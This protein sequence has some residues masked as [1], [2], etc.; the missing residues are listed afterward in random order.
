MRDD[1][2]KVLVERPRVRG[3]FVP[4]RTGRRYVKA[5]RSGIESGDGS[6]VQEGIMR[7]YRGG[8]GRVKH[9]NEHLGP[10]RRF[11]ESNVGRPWDKV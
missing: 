7:R 6:P 5:V 10:L 8:H 3:G 11:V 2:G 9:F 4:G 1:M